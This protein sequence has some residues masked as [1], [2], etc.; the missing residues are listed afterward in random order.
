[1]RK[2]FLKISFIN[3][4]VFLLFSTILI[5]SGCSCGSCSKKEESQIPLEVLKKADR[6]IIAKT[7]EDFFTKYITADFSQSK[8]I[9]PNYLI[10]YKLY[11]PEKP[12]VD[13][14]IRFTTD[15]LGNVLTKYEVFGIPDCNS[16]STICDFVVDEKIA[17]Q[18]ASQ[19]GLSE[20]INDWKINFIWDAKYN[21]YVWQILSTLQE[22]KGEFGYRGEGERMIIDPNNA[23]V[24]IKDTWRVN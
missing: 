10:V 6:F 1:M 8:H 11:M 16:D 17:K 3:L 13:G 4:S 2:S 5:Y 9:A 14:L 19:S 7:G 22:N 20:G 24:I 15:S 12:F 23:F 21:K 18:I